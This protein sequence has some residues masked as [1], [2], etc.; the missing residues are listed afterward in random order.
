MVAK[1]G[2]R[3]CVPCISLGPVEVLIGLLGQEVI[4]V[5]FGG[6]Q[7]DAFYYGGSTTALNRF[8]AS[9]KSIPLK[10]NHMCLH[11][12]YSFQYLLCVP[13]LQVDLCE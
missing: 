8:V 4:L 9:N 1:P 13:M 5:R 11:F 6:R 2:R 12:I 7:K 3:T 10:V